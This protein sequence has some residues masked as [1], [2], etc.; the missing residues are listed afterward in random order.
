MLGDG[1]GPECAG[2]GTAL[3]LRWAEEEMLPRSWDKTLATTE[4]I[5]MTQSHGLT[6]KSGGS[7]RKWI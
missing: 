4:L 2:S 1:T 3:C 6:R 5:H 7:Q